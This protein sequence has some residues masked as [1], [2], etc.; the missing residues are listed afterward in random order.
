MGGWERGQVHGVGM[1][2][3]LCKLMLMSVFSELVA[4][5]FLCTFIQIAF[6]EPMKSTMM[7]PGI[8]LSNKVDIF[9]F[10]C[11]EIPNPKVRG[12]H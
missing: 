3:G 11:K 5:L 1:G 2:R 10:R 9:L 8:F 4:D 12:T 7:I 6:F